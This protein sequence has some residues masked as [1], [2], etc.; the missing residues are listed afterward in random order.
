[1]SAYAY[2]E[3]GSVSSG[4]I[5]HETFAAWRHHLLT[6]DIGIE[7]ELVQ[8]HGGS[9]LYFR[10]PNGHSIEVGTSGLWSN[11]LADGDQRL[12]C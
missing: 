6:L 7:S 11:D 5:A 4:P 10:D 9:S 2:R 8:P 1:M 3:G 12:N